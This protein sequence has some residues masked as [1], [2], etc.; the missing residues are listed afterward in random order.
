M[1]K[2]DK[3]IENALA[4]LIASNKRNR[5]YV[6]DI[7]AQCIHFIGDEKKT[8]K[9]VRS[10]CMENDIQLKIIDVLEEDKGQK[11]NLSELFDE[12]QKDC[13]LL[14]LKDYTKTRPNVRYKFSCIYK[15]QCAPNEYGIVK[16]EG[17]EYLGTIIISSNDDV[18]QL[19]DSERS[20]FGHVD[21]NK[22]KEDSN[23]DDR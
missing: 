11:T 8:E 13:A 20:C 6:Q 18:F 2:I 3:I 19:D 12:L 10:F 21:L 22:K 16:K 17:L 4:R 5:L 9:K 1:Y 23:Y 7:H 14:Y 15:N